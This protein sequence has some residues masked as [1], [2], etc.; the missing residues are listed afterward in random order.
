MTVEGMGKMDG[1]LNVLA[2]ATL[3]GEVVCPYSL[4]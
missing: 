2:L 4:F 1:Y 3:R